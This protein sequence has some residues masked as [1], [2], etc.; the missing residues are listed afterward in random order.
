MCSVVY[1]AYIYVDESQNKSSSQNGW[2]II[3]K[4]GYI[5]QKRL[6]T[7]ALFH[8]CIA[9]KYGSIFSMTNSVLCRLNKTV[10][11]TLL[12][13]VRNINDNY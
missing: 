5:G 3:E 13:F 4:R 8:I 1:I 10:G 11:F 7:K 6:R 12:C 9:S 2:V